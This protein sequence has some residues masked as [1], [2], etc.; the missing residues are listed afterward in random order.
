MTRPRA[1]LP[2]LQLLSNGRCHVMVT[3]EGTGFSRWKGL[4][5]SRWHED[6]T[7]DALGQFCYVQDA[8]GGRPWSA[9]AQPTGARGDRVEATFVPGGASLLRWHVSGADPGAPEIESRTEIAV[10]PEDDVEWR[11]VSLSLGAGA[12]RSLTLTSYMEVV[13]EAPAA[14][15]AHPAF[16]KLFVQTEILPQW[17]A[18][19]CTRRPRAPEDPTPWMFHLL[20]PCG[21]VASKVSYE[22]D[23]MRFIGRGR[24]TADPQ[25]L[26]SDAALSGTAGAVL[27]PVAAIR[28]HVEL[29]AGQTV[30][31][32]WV[33]G[34]AASREACLALIRKC[35]EPG[36]ADSVRVG[37]EAF[38]RQALTDLH[39]SQADALRCNELAA[40]IVF[41]DA[42]MRAPAAVLA[43]NTQG[44]SGLWRFAI[45]G[46]LPVVLATLHDAAQ[47]A[48][49]RQLVQAHAVWRGH[50]LAVDLVLLVA[51]AAAAGAPAS[52][53][54]AAV[55][56][57]VALAGQA[58]S[59]AKP[60]GIFV[61]AADAVGVE[62]RLL[63]QSV[64]RVVL[65]AGDGELD[66]QLASRRAHAVALEA[67][68]RPAAPGGAPAQA[69]APVGGKA[70][71]AFDNG[72]GGFSADGREYVITTSAARM[73]PLPWINVLAN[74][75]FGTLVSESGSASTW[76]ENAQQFLLTPW[77]NDPVGDANT[78]AFYIRDEDSGRCW[79]PTLL[80]APATDEGDLPY[81]TRH[82][83]GYS[84]FE[85]T[86]G[87]IASQLTMFVALAAPIKFVVLKLRNASGRARRLSV[88]GYVEWV[89]G[90]AREKMAM[91]VGTALDA[92]CGALFARNPGNTDFAGR[93]AFFDA[94]AEGAEPAAF[95]VCGDRSAFIGRGG[96]LRAPAAMSRPRLCGTVGWALDP[97]A[98]IRLPVELAPGQTRVIVFRLGAGVTVDQ[99]RQLVL[100]WR[101]A[102]AAQEAL[103]AV[104][105]YW[106][107]TLGAVQVQTP[108]RAL[109]ILAN[110]WL[111]YQALSCRLW[112]R[113]AFYQASGAFGFRD[114]LQDVMALVH[115]VPAL[116]REH[117]LRSASR[118]FPE[119]DVQHWW[120]P[121][122][123]RGVRT[124]CSDDA[125]WLPLAT[126]R[127]VQVTGDTGVLDEPVLFV[128][129]PALK[130]GEVSRYGLPVPSL[131]A[132]PLYAH[133]RLAIEH[134]L[135]FGTHGLPLMGS[136]D[137]NDGMNLVGVQ[138]QGESVWLGFFLCFVLKQ[139]GELAQQRQDGAFAQR[140]HA[141]S[142]RLAAAIEA[143]A[144][145]GA[146]WR[147]AWFDDGSPL[148]TAGNVEC[149]IDGIAQSWAV[150]SGAGDA[151]RSRLAMQALDRL[152]V[153]RDAALVRLLT[154]PFEHSSPSP[155]YIQGY[156]RG[157]RENG[158]QYTHAAVWA[159]MAFAA[160][161]DGRRA[162]ELFDMLNPIRHADSPPAIQ[163]YKAEPYVVAGDVYALA[164]HAGRGGWSWYTGSPGWLYRCILESLLGLQ[165]EG[166][167]LRLRPCLPSHWD[168]C[169]VNY[170]H[171]AT[172]Y[173]IQVL[174]TAL[175]GAADVWTVD[176]QALEGSCLS[177]I[178]DGAEHT[179]VVRLAS[180]GAFECSSE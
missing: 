173:R 6:A 128:E 24:S 25:A 86:A 178:D 146:W 175:A 67:P 160:Q 95:S 44:Q 49:V 57:A 33:T 11:R 100:R 19:V 16:E 43:L 165:V 7:C 79:S 73:T 53:L 136:C 166:A 142:A 13:L 94:D 126:A 68:P 171:R 147:R 109:D 168:G 130:D 58:A 22:T 70:G 111:V 155:G 35:R 119:G 72:F 125:L 176:G 123:G 71:L 41:A 103:A 34:I 152:L 8:A 51:P 112:A 141:E 39:C 159:A 134:G 85:H 18:I 31:V 55:L 132:Q 148:G 121:P 162:W 179:V 75:G 37:A 27:D 110:G 62:G 77:S 1:P 131:T 164:P 12:A 137:W 96:S 113:T 133:C 29:H 59:I 54:Q 149:R 98:A 90:D 46:D 139:F 153:D 48:I 64:A 92:A 138:G 88:T 99:A 116:V 80:P 87:G 124:R 2:R 117:L 45:S 172:L 81:V 107:H 17:Q 65:D 91:H 104:K 60:G 89:L 169:S 127:Y 82:G 83:F 180:K 158:G 4:A 76:S 36:F 9:T 129:G 21:G 78:E 145:D 32:D 177:M 93:T 114:Q 108:D 174:P 40:A 50:G 157:V 61:L 151:A 163:I 15:A 52:G 118:Q 167:L 161:G 135:R 105:Q 47:M 56:D 156:V 84:V 74:P 20:L 26:D 102:A 154:P 150:L 14:D 42:A 140:C 63:L 101:G 144:W 120:H 3:R 97:C 28:C 30:A 106:S 66:A 170:R 38:A 5:L 115:A 23:R 10:A 122:S 69:A 143:S